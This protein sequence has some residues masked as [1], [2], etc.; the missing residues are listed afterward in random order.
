MI[1]I[2]HPYLRVA[3]SQYILSK[4]EIRIAKK[5]DALVKNARTEC[6]FLYY[7]C[8]ND[9]GSVSERANFRQREVKKPSGNIEP[10]FETYIDISRNNLW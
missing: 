5:I 1:N 8:S 7:R 10:P 6:F 4:Q 2:I 9:E 3:I